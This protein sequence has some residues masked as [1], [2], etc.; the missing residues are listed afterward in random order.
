[1]FKSR[2]FIVVFS[3]IIASLYIVGCQ[4]EAITTEDDTQ[5]EST[6]KRIIP[7]IPFEPDFRPPNIPNPPMIDEHCVV[8]LAY[9][10]YLERCP[11]NASVVNYWIGVLRRDDFGGL[12]VGFINSAEANQRW[13]HRYNAFLHRNN[14]TSHD[15]AKKVYIAYRGLLLREP[16]VSGGMY[17]TNILNT[18]SLLHVA[19]GIGNSPEFARRRANFPTECSNAANRCTF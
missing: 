18:R 7:Q 14:I 10:S 4:S 13:T 2:H 6:A 11:E 17:W 19:N 5:I 3:L 16:D 8:R 1:M 12:A 15:I 9:L